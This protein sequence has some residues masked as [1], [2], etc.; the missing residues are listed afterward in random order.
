VRDLVT[1]ADT[2]DTACVPDRISRT[3]LLFFSLT[4]VVFWLPAVR[5]VFD[6]PSY[7][8]GLA[9][10]SGRG[11]GGDYWFPAGAAAA[12]LTLLAGGWRCRWWAFAAIT[13]WNVVMLAA[14]TAAAA[15]SPG[16]FRFRGATLGIDVSL[17]WLGPVLFGTAATLS[18]V[19]ARRHYRRRVAAA[20]WGV[21][22]R[23]WTLL[24][25]SALPIQFVLLRVGTPQSTLDAV[26]VLITIAQWLM[27]GRVFRPHVI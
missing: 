11:V 22:N 23:R 26:G 27:V 9:G 6:G 2:G 5:G 24:L 15:S 25:A 16:E 8:W 21:H 4:T 12:A 1:R 17:V 3:A 7:Q 18:G 19:A 10:F 13:A 20:S 14:V